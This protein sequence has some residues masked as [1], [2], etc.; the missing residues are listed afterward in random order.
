M[1]RWTKV[2]L[3]ASVALGALAFEVSPAAADGF[4]SPRPTMKKRFW[5][6]WNCRCRTLA[7]IYRTPA[8]DYSA[9]YY[10]SHRQYTRIRHY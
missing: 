1:Q 9:Y 6:A 2:V 10:S 3:C 7:E 5:R 8:Q 4:H